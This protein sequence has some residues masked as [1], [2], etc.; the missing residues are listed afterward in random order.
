MARVDRAELARR[1]ARALGDVVYVPRSLDDIERELLDALNRL[2]DA[3]RAD[4]FGAHA[5]FRVGENL[6]SAGF[7]KPACVSTSIT[8]LGA[9]MPK[10]PDVERIDGLPGKVAALAAELSAGFAHGVR[11]RLFAEQ[12]DIKRALTRAKEKVEQDLATSEALFEEIFASSTV[13]MAVSDLD[14]SL[15]RVNEALAG[16]LA[17]PEG[18]LSEKKV[19]ELFHPEHADYLRVRYQELLTG[20]ALPFRERRKLLRSDGEEA[21]VYLSVSLLSTADGSP[22]YFVTTAEDIY[23]KHSLE[24]QLAHQSTHDSLTG[25]ANR[26]RFI[27]RVEEALD[28]KQAAEEVTLLHVNLDGFS[29]VNAGPGRHV[30]DKLLQAVADRLQAVVADERATVARLTA[31]EFAILI[32]H[33]PTT[34]NVGTIAARINEELA[35]PVYVEGHGVAATAT[36]AV[37]RQPPAK[38]NPEDLL[39]ATDITIRRLKSA[40]RRQWGFVEEKV[41]AEYRDRC[42]LAASMPGAWESGEI[43]VDYQP[44]VTVAGRKLIAVQALLRWDNPQRGILDH[45]RCCEALEESGLSVPIGRWLLG[46]ACQEATGWQAPPGTDVEPTLYVELTKQQACDPDLVTNVR[47]ALDESGLRYRRLRLGMPVRALCMADGQ[48]ESNLDVLHD[49]GVT[50]VLYEFGT[51]RGDLACMEDLQVSVVKMARRVVSRVARGAERESV[52]AKAIQQLVPL[53]HN[54]GVEVYAGFVE[55]ESQ[56]AWWREIGADAAQGPLFGGPGPAAAISGLLP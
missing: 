54:H 32:E 48:A 29:A 35:E 24:W 36:V 44:I 7:T 15:V 21:L 10:L 39:Q 34:P 45:D 51:T 2:V 22:R 37:L 42:R 3:V 52:F 23:D 55:T 30:G 20:G 27:G 18:E 17:Y 47:G 26:H 9:D 40:G 1:W 31:D 43:D 16:I 4:E 38:A 8:M 13:G 50:T 12:A 25:L 41:D 56:A 46:R 49:I 19:P 5:A 14:G 33:S 6:V 53:V 28:G 11:E